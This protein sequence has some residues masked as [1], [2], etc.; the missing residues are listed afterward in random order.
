[1]YRKDLAS[2][3]V[4]ALKRATNPLTNRLDARQM[5]MN[6]LNDRE[7]QAVPNVTFRTRDDAGWQDVTS[8][9]LF[10]GKTVVVFSLPGAFTPTCS[11]THLPRYEEL[12]P[13]FAANGVDE[14]LCVSVNDGF[15]MQA[16]QRDQGIEKVRVIPDGNGHFTAGMGMLVDKEDLGFGKRSWR[17][18]MLVKNGVVDKMFI[19]PDLPGDPFTVSDAD[20]MLAYINASAKA[21]EPVAVISR[22]G[23]PHCQ[24]AKDLLTAR[25]IRFNE[26]VVGR[27]IDQVAMRGLT[28][29][30][31]VPQVFIGGQLI[32]GADQLTTYLMKAS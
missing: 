14:I 17:Y 24:R 7:G 11:A 4:I 1:M 22:T 19:E 5:M 32:G 3:A 31:S 15:V 10:D 30:M 13:V 27:D 21:P 2:M 28:G 12:A 20:T 23:C 18:S 8:Q 16:W 26:I 9:A 29:S 25:Q 6:T